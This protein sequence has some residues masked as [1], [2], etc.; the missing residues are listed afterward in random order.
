VDRTPGGERCPADHEGR[1]VSGPYATTAL[2]LEAF[3]GATFVEIADD[4]HGGNALAYALAGWEIIPLRGKVPW[5]PGVHPP[6][7]ACKGECGRDGHGV[8]DATT[9][10]RE[11][12]RDA[13]QTLVAGSGGERTR[14]DL[15]VPVADELAALAATPSRRPTSSS[16]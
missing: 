7:H 6:G 1:P 13:S 4:D 3:P 12:T 11:V 14:I 16:R 8:L 15:P 9:N 2:I 5:I 10:L